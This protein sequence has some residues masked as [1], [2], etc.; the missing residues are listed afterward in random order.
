MLLFALTCF[1]QTEK[2]GYLVG[3]VVD[4][5]S[6][7]QAG[8][9][10]NFNMSIAPA[11]GV[12][13]VKNFAIGGRYAFGVTGTKSYNK[14]KAKYIAT[15]TFTSSI[16]PALRYYIGK[17]PLKGLVSANV[18]YLTAT[19]LHDKSVS[20]YNGFSAGGFL[21]MAYFFNPHVSIEAGGYITVAGY[22]SEYPTTRF[23]F[24]VGFF[25]FLDKKKKE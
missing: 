18:N 4:V 7:K 2:G 11:F 8:S 21:G 23:G 9:T 10:A 13:V 3:G 16:G 20:G 25:T 17:K 14:S 1:S 22:T 12:F 15:T 24:S 5:S 6:T 19:V